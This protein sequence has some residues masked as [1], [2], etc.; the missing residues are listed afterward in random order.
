[1]GVQRMQVSAIGAS[2][3]FLLPK[4]AQDWTG[5]AAVSILV[6]FSGGG[7]AVGTVSL[8]VSNDPLANTTPALAR[9]N[10]HDTLV[11]LT[12]DANATIAAPIY[13]ARLNCTAYTS[14]TITADL[15]FADNL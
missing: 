5:N 4:G 11:N 6:N 13:A 14:G 8:Q 10:N 7:P 3:P 12:G 9:W 1:M 2:A 15:G